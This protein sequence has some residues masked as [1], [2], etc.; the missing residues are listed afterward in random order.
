MSGGLFSAAAVEIDFKVAACPKQYFIYGLIAPEVT[1]GGVIDLSVGEEQLTFVPV[2]AQDQGAGLVS[3]IQRLEQVHHV[4]LGEVAA[5]DRFARRLAR[6]LLQRNLVHNFFD[7]CRGIFYE[8]WLLD[9]VFHRVLKRLELLRDVSLVG[10]EDHGDMGGGAAALKLLQELLAIDGVH[11]EVRNDQIRLVING[12]KQRVSAICE[13]GDRT[14][15]GKGLPQHLQNHGIVV[16]EQNLD[17]GWH[18]LLLLKIAG[19][20]SPVFA[21][22][23][24]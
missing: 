3:H 21:A 1:V 4:H 10:H 14:E 20:L 6:H 15:M 16:N 23:S 19:R 24:T 5:Q 22:L 11:G 17:V 18:A 12:L 9:E 13:R 2:I 8:K 7:S